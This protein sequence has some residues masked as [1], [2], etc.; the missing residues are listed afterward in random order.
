MTTSIKAA[1]NELK[2]LVAQI[3]EKDEL[4]KSI[5]ESNE[6]A[7]D[8]QE[9]VKEATENYKAVLAANLDYFTIENEKKE[10]VKELA[11]GAKAA[12]KN[13]GFKPSVLTAFLKA[14]LKD[15]GVEKV[16]SKGG[17]FS[18]LMGQTQ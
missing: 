14:S 16:V 17:D 1:A 10:L 13:T 8:A 4:L 15:A 11:Q 5:K 7:L 9:A 2:A 6:K 18:A 3:A 12:T